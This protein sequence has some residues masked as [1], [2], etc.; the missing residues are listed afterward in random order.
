MKT[1]RSSWQA[2]MMRC[3]HPSSHKYPRYG[4]RG[5]SVC[6]RWHDFDRFLEDMGPR[7]AGCTL[8]RVNNDGDYC[9]ENCRW[10]DAII[11]NRNRSDNRLI[12]F[13]GRTQCLTAWAEEIGLNR[14]TLRKR[15][16][17]GWPIEKAL[18]TRR[19]ENGHDYP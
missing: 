14:T 13:R 15:I 1:T 4:G 3:Y 18:T 19:L 9:P 16:D 12:S 2:M 6:D 5:I 10:A 11:Q 7:P 17:M 8:D